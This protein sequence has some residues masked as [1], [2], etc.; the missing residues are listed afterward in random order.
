MRASSSKIG[1]VLTGLLVAGNAAA[2]RAPSTVQLPTFSRFSVSTTVLAPD[3][4]SGFLGGVGKAQSGYGEF[5]APYLPLRTLRNA[6]LGGSRGTSGAYVSAT[7]HDMHEMDEWLLGQPA[8]HYGVPT[9]ALPRP[10][11]GRKALEF[12]N[13]DR[14]VATM[15]FGAAWTVLPTA[16]VGDAPTAKIEQIRAERQ[17]QREARQTE[18]EDLF[19]RGRKAE[20]AGKKGVARIYYQ[21]A[22]RRAA[23]E[24]KARAVARLAAVT[25]PAA[26]SKTAPPTPLTPP[27]SAP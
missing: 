25:A 6:S 5:G 7:I 23:G 1:T 14:A 4:G 19:E 8:T 2:Q 13:R 11:I 18:A 9:F 24:L 22:A 20:D 3:S 15:D 17:Q 26:A 12:D 27:Q 16:G 10:L 21:M